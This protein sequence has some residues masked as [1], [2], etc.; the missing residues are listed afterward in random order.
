MKVC[1]NR[2]LK[3][4]TVHFRCTENT[5]APHILSCLQWFLK[6][7]KVS[8]FLRGVC[9]RRVPWVVLKCHPYG[10]TSLTVRVMKFTNSRS[11][12]ALILLSSENLKTKIKISRQI[13]KEKTFWGLK[14]KVMKCLDML[15]VK[16]KIERAISCQNTSL[17]VL[18]QW[19]RSLT[20]LWSL[21]P[22]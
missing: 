6:H 2:S 11:R 15:G 17:P 19:M 16:A 3:P 20:L 22:K 7:K 18:C 1:Q 12:Q 4:L 9:L 8:V 21:K 13:K 14:T 5:C 10:N